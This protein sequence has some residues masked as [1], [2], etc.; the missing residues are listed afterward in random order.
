M[1]PTAPTIRGLIK[2][3]KAEVP[4]RPIINWRNAPA[5]KIAKALT[6]ILSIHIP[7]PYAYNV[8]NSTQLI[9]DLQDIKYNRDLRLASFGIS[10]MYT[11]IPT[12]KLLGIIDTICKNNNIDRNIRTSQDCQKP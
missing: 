9:K 11:N 1:N 10:N 12:K 8:K 7:L 4:I 2:I 5:Y 6:K 3:H